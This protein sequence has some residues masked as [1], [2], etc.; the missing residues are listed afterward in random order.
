MT[1]SHI[2]LA[3]T[4]DKVSGCGKFQWKIAIGIE[5]LAGVFVA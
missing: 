5:H 2:C 4:I 3:C 1:C